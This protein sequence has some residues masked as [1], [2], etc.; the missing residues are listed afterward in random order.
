[1]ERA[2]KEYEYC[3]RRLRQEE[4]AARSASCAAARERHEELAEAY[5]LR[6]LLAI[7]RLQS[8]RTHE[9]IGRW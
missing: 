1:M 3:K 7:E 4:K 8:S 6:T 5:R 2:V 9:L